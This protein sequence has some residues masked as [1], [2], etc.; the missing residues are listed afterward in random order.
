MAGRPVNR[1]PARVLSIAGTDPTGGAGVQADLKS[2][3]ANGGYGM[4]VVTALVAQNTRGVRSVHVPPVSFLTA[5]LHSVSEDVVIDAVKIGMLG[6]TEVIAAATG[7]LDE[8]RPRIVVLDPVMVASSGD[9]LLEAD[10]ETAIVS[11]L[12]RCDLVTPN[13]PELAI[14]S[15][16]P[17]AA[18]WDDVVAQAA[19]VAEAYGVAVLAKG[20]HL[21][22]DQAPDALVREIDGRIVV[23]EFPGARVATTNTHGTGCSFSSA[24]ATRLA[25]DLGLEEAI[26]TSKAW[27]TESIRRADELDVGA[28]NGPI[29]HFAGLWGRGGL[30]TAPTTDEVRDEWWSSI[31]AIREGIDALPFVRG[32]GDGSLPREEFLWY[33]EQDALYLVAYSRALAA[34]SRLAP[35]IG[36]QTFWASCAHSALATEKQLHDSWLHQGIDRSSVSVSSATTEAYLAHLAAAVDS[37]DYPVLVAALLPCF[38][39]YHDVGTR[40]H[41]LSHAEHPYRSWLDTYADPLF[42]EANADAIRIATTAA[43]RAD[44]P[45][46]VRMRR[47]FVES[48]RHELRFFA[49]PTRSRADG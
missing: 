22:G 49:A 18:D 1:R 23:A 20:G 43:V 11:L 15:A 48:S 35:D 8:V 3:A 37:G 12:S 25:S 47:A 41:P 30:V 32:L 34:A 19:S 27:L 42:A 26:R 10:A 13:I 45:T 17:T 28:G 40:L 36:D 38:W 7:W 46:R 16:S 2:I 39:L 14:L 24:I 31:G 6:T 29:H 33:L 5:Q 9:R 4:A 44:E 21:S